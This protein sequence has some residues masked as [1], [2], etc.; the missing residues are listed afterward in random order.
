LARRIKGFFGRLGAQAVRLATE[1]EL[2]LCFQ[3]CEVR[4]T[5]ALRHWAGVDVFMDAALNIEGG[6][7]QDQG[8]QHESVYV[9]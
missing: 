2:A 9:M 7:Y 8:T 4:A 6:I 1:Q 3:D 5:P